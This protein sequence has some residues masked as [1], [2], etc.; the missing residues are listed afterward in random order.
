MVEI[1]PRPRRRRLDLLDVLRFVA[2][3]GVVASHWTF[4]GVLHGKI[5][6]VSELTPVAGPARYGYVGVQLFFLISGYVIVGSARG[7]SARQFVVGRLARL[8]PA[9]WVSVLITA[10]VTAVAGAVSH[11]SVSPAQ[12]LVN[13]TM[14]PGLFG[15]EAVDSVYWTLV[16][17]LWFYALVAVALLAGRLE[18]LIRLMPAWAVLILGATLL[19]G[20]DPSAP[21]VGAYFAPFAGGVILA[22]ARR[23]GW[24]GAR[25]VGLAAALAVSVVRVTD[26]AG[27]VQRNTGEPVSETVA[28]AL[29][30]ACF[31]VV[32]V[33]GHPRLSSIAVPGAAAM[34][35]LT[36]P[37]YLLHAD[38]GYISLSHLVRVVPVPVAYAIALAGV[39]GL[40][41][42]VHVLVERR[43]AAFWVRTFDR[44]VGAVSDAVLPRVIPQVP[45]VLG[46]HGQGPRA[47][48]VPARPA[49]DPS[50]GSSHTPGDP[51]SRAPRPLR[52]P[53]VPEPLW[54]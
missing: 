54:L 36:Y 34:G 16:L 5:Q 26:L 33:V 23:E 20:P 27:V 11:L 44:A 52:P 1:T 31:A 40:A 22:S 7:K 19:V 21:Y 15:V 45:A 50:R 18:T 6:G 38:L 4:G 46:A 39:L 17:E 51:V 47:G 53:N 8:Y 42:S 3:M 10:A 24:S 37:L 28:A 14:A 25:V 30:V 32:A 35:A 9:F 12:V 29:V 41:W 43:P 2:A 49:T 13:L 48:H